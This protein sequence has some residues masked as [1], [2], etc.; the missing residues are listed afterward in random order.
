MLQPTFA[1]TD[2]ELERLRRRCRGATLAAQPSGFNRKPF[3]V[4]LLK[5]ACP[6]A[7]AKIKHMTTEEVETLC[8]AVAERHAPGPGP[9]DLYTETRQRAARI[10][11]LSLLPG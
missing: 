2:H 9:D 5:D 6:T 3:L 4:R 8:A 11:A 10:A 1:L 7:A